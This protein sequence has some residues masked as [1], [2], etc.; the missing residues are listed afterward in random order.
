MAVRSL[1]VRVGVEV[2]LDLVNGPI[3]PNVQSSLLCKGAVRDGNFNAL[4]SKQDG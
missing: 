3:S 2:A 4:A 1:C